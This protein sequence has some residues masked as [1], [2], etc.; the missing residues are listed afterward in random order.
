EVIDEGGVERGR[1]QAPLHFDRVGWERHE[2]D[3]GGFT[4]PVN[5][6]VADPDPRCVTSYPDTAR[7]RNCRVRDADLALS[8]HAAELNGELGRN[9]LCDSGEFVKGRVDDEHLAGDRLEADAAA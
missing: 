3:R 1:E 5:E 9:I 2:L 7:T 4:E 6:G 8:R